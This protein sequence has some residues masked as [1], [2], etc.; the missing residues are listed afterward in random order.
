MKG[1][2]PFLID[3]SRLVGRLMKGRLPTG[4]DRVALAYVSQY[5]ER[6]RAFVRDGRFHVVLTEK[7][8]QTLF[9]LLL[10]PPVDFKAHAWR[11]IAQGAAAGIRQR[12]LSGSVFLNIGHSG[13]EYHRYP[14]L[15][16]KMK[17]RPVFLVHDL[18]PITHPEYCRPGEGER[19]RIRMKTVLELAQGVI[20][21]SQ[22][23]L[24][25]LARFADA[26]GI[27]LPPA[28]PAFLA[29]P[30]FPP[31][32]AVR[33]VDRPYF[34][35]LG[36]IEPRKNHL[37]L[38]QVW[39]R[40]VE[41]LGNRAPLLVLI[42]QRGWECENVVD[43]LERCEAVKGHIIE[44]ASCSDSELANWLQYAQ[45][46][47]F[48]SF[49]EGFGLPLVEA[50]ACG[51]PVIASDLPVFH[52]IAGDLPDYCDPLDALGWLGLITDYSSSDSRKRT[53]QLQ[54]ISGYHPPT[55]QDHFCKVELLLQ[56][57]TH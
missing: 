8:S 2:Y 30:V 21:N 26:Q 46:L 23:T 35:V 48:P 47:L 32:S 19:H 49:V 42:G 28:Q 37:L 6:S 10:T 1:N 17:V 38:L 50:L 41:Q 3:V 11:L 54:R 33:L 14:D 15:L 43:L 44:H 5:G 24:D 36:T 27:C 31:P 53:E 29:P 22:A 18:I 55:W 16:R 52:E 39:K 45:A 20:T 40:L 57:L 9:H 56:Q 12:D 51:T 7:L 25:E 13:L 4:V 34:V